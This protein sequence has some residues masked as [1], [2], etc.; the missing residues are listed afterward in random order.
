MNAVEIIPLEY[1]SY[2]KQQQLS[3]KQIHI[4]T[5]SMQLECVFVLE[6]VGN[7]VLVLQFMWE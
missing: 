2:N 6:W 1:T 5:Y 3:V 4:M 7:W